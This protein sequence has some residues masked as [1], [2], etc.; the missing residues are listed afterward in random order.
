MSLEY[1]CP[2]FF[3]SGH[4]QTIFPHFF[5]R[6]PAPAFK[7]ERIDTA[8]GD[9][10]DLD[11]LRTGNTRLVILSHG[12]GGNSDSPYI[13][14]AARALSRRGWDVLAW[15]FRGC[16]G[17]PNR[18]VSS[19]HSG[20]TDDLGLII[21]HAAPWYQEIALV[22]FSIGGNITLKYLGEMGNRLPSEISSAVTVSVPCDLRSSAVALSKKHNWVYMQFFL[23]RLHLKIRQKMQLFPGQI[24]DS[25]FENIKNFF[26]YDQ[27]YTAPHHGF[28]SVDEYYTLNSSRLYIPG[29]RVPT[30][31]V[32]AL[33]DSFLG[34][35]GI[36]FDECASNPHVRLETPH[37]GGHVGFVSSG[38][39][40]E[41]WSETRTSLFLEQHS[42][43]VQ[44][45]S[46]NQVIHLAT[47]NEPELE[48][49]LA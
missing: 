47:R 36:P 17:E 2:R 26:E 41:Y 31:I 32:S 9:F 4:L 19:F 49:K 38:K 33:N 23:K 18:L 42:S 25:G 12:L 30:L 14:G 7:R 48:R 44:K 40:A 29:I 16:S 35:D 24:D 6:L 13:R 37:H 21:D 15:N 5:R 46:D 39:D 10:L 28:E 22:G 3:K 1:R 20:K 8:D 45:S 43:G 11:W 27:R 34:D